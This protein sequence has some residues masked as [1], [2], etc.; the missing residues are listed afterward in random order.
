MTTAV[1]RFKPMQA[2]AAKETDVAQDDSGG[3]KGWSNLAAKGRTAML[4]AM[5]VDAVT[6]N[7]EVA[8]MR[9][10]HPNRSNDE[11]AAALYSR[12][13][14]KAAAAVAIA[15]LPANMMVALP[16]AAVDAGIVLRMEVFAACCVGTLYEPHFVDSR[17]VPWEVLVPIF[18]A[19]I[20]SQALRE[21][22]VLGSQQLTKQ[23]IRRVL[24]KETL[25]AFQS[26]MLKAFG[27]K[28]TQRAL[29]SKWV[30]IVGSI[31][32][33]TWNWV[34]VSAQGKRVRRYFLDK[35]V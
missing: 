16:A 6:V 34:E 20:A 2:A 13:A 31:I 12:Q 9:A 35:P 29:V 30:P 25:K 1:G 11:H 7:A 23:A 28:V 21:L 15:G 17:E 3:G 5:K 18:G 27:I 33:G 8:A 14:W 22:G 24:T 26:V 10:A 32:G 4:W 19:N